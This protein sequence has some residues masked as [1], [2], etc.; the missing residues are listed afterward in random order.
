MFAFNEIFEKK[1]IRDCLKRVVRTVMAILSILDPLDKLIQINLTFV[2]RIRICRCVSISVFNLVIIRFT[3]GW[4]GQTKIKKIFLVL[5]DKIWTT[6][7]DLQMITKYYILQLQG[8]IF[9][10]SNAKKVVNPSILSQKYTHRV[11]KIPE[12]L[13]NVRKK[14]VFC[15]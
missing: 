1:R 11:K 12:F 6:D 9:Q 2:H 3:Q 14:K 13:E 7:L 10:A 8:H 5:S 15:L 4:L